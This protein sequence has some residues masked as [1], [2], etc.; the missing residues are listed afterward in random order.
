MKISFCMMGNTYNKEQHL[1]HN[2]DLQHLFNF[3]RNLCF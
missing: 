1:Q 3:G 2:K